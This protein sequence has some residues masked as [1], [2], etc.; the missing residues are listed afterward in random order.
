[1]KDKVEDIITDEDLIKAF[2]RA[3]FGDRSSKRDIVR[4]TLLRAASGYYNGYTS[5]RIIHALGL[6]TIKRIINEVGLVKE[7]LILTKKGKEYLYEAFRNGTN[8]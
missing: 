1:M 6:T 4:Y 5:Q 2:E 8:H 7:E 3:N